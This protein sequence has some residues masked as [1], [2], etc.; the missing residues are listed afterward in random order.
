MKER[1]HGPICIDREK[2]NVTCCINGWGGGNSLVVQ[3]LGLCALTAEVLGSIPRQ[4]TK[5]PQDVKKWGGD[6]VRVGA[7]EIRMWLGVW[8]G[9]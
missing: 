6:S 2:I 1:S 4:G 8:G 9:G 7:R 5:T 3:W